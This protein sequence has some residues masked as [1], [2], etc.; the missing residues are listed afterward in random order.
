MMNS[1][2]VYQSWIATHQLAGVSPQAIGWIFSFYTFFSFFAGLFLGPIFDAKGPRAISF[3]GGTLLILMYLGL[4]LCR[5]YWEFFFCIGFVGGLS[6][7]C[8]FTCAISCVQHWFSK[9]RGLATGIALSGGSI[10]GMIFPSLFGKLL[11]AVGFARGTMVA[12]LILLPFVVCAVCFMRARVAVEEEEEDEG[13]KEPQSWLPQLGILRSPMVALTTVGLVL[14]EL[15]MYLPV[16]YLASYA[17]HWHQTPTVASRILTYLSLGSLFGRWSPALLSLYLGPAAMQTLGLTLCSAATFC[18][19][20]PAGA[21][22]V[23]IVVYAFI[24]GIGSGCVITTS[25]LCVAKLC[26][27]TEYGRYVTTIYTVSSLG[28]VDAI[29]CPISC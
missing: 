13:E 11:P 14:N 26:K 22:M 4:G 23:N 20:F 6:T 18:I 29:L 7:S 19:W 10:S 24:F 8:L 12:T 16:T 17:L 28:Y 27:T 9:K 21:N 1:I 15:A 5:N 25:S 3:V 2:G